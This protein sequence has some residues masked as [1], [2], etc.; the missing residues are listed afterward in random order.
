MAV[1]ECLVPGR[2]AAEESTN[3]LLHPL[4]WWQIARG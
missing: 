4:V 3:F 1:K 2:Q